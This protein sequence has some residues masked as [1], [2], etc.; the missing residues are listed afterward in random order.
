MPPPSPLLPPPLPHFV[1]LRPKEFLLWLA[2]FQAA[3]TSIQSG[4]FDQAGVKAFLRPYLPFWRE[5]FE[6]AERDAAVF[7]PVP[8]NIERMI[9]RG[10]SLREVLFRSAL[11]RLTGWQFVRADNYLLMCTAT[12]AFLHWL[13]GV[14][15]NVEDPDE[16]RKLVTL[17]ADLSG[18]VTILSYGEVRLSRFVER[19]DHIEHYCCTH[20]RRPH[21]LQETLQ[22]LADLPW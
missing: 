6:R 15:Y 1:P 14:E 13:D 22:M 10:S 19:I 17:R 7:A 12:L 3:S 9:Q 16:L 18:G 20:R 2:F 5:L 11:S 21:P 4:M 8:I